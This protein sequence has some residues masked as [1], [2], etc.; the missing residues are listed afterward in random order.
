MVFLLIMGFTTF[1]TLLPTASSHYYFFLHSFTIPTKAQEYPFH[2]RKS[3]IRLLGSNEVK[4]FE[5]IGP[6]DQQREHFLE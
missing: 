1:M 5:H 2:E 6:E 4:N 3:Q